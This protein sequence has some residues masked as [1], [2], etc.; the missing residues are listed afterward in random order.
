M[1]ASIQPYGLGR[2]EGLRRALDEYIPK[3]GG[4]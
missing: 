4:R 2:M 3:S 1:F